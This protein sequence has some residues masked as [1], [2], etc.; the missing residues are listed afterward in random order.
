M[1]KNRPARLYW[2]SVIGTPITKTRE[3]Y[4]MWQL[5]VCVYCEIS[6]MVERPTKKGHWS[7]ESIVGRSIENLCKRKM[8][9]VVFKLGYVMVEFCW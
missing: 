5:L 6:G 7:R 3:I 2:L 8:R 1:T 9:S 4:R